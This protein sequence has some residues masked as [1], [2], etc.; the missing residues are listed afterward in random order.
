MAAQLAAAQEGLCSVSKEV[1]HSMKMFN[2]GETQVYE[3]LK[4][5]TEMLKWW[6]NCA[7]GEIKRKLKKTVNEDVNKIV[8]E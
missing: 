7:N 5:E 2:T 8:W 4:K 1:K 6:D 3:I